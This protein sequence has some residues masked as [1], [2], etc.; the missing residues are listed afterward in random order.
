MLI[1]PSADVQHAKETN[2]PLPTVPI[3]FLKPDTALCGPS[4]DNIVVPKF[5]QVDKSADYESE[6]AVII[7]Q[8]CKDV[9]EQDAMRY[10]LGYTAANDVSSRK[11]QFDTS[12]WT[13][14]KG[15][16]NSCP[17]GESYESPFRCF[18]S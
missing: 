17:L 2:L 1:F 7:G 8:N 18:G 6:M 4:P 5:T 15:F 12:Q 11:S 14:S 10:V 16:D 9:T 13:F 3:V